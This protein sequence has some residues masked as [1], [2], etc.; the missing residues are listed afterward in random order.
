MDSIRKQNA[1]Q[2]KKT[3]E[4][5]HNTASDV[6]KQILKKSKPDL[7]FPIRSLKNVSYS[8]K[9]GFFEI[10]KLKKTRTLTVNTVK[11]FA[12]TLRM[13]GLSNQ[14]GRLLSEQELGRCEV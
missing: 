6:H 5:I 3:V 1:A 9:N 7:S 4:Q 8:E 14:K 11:G 10:G 12:Q 13:I 2:D